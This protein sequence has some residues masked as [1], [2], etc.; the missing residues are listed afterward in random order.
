MV[1][2]L[3]STYEY[4]EEVCTA[5]AEDGN[6]KRKEI[7]APLAIVTSRSSIVYGPDVLQYKLDEHGLEVTALEMFRAEYALGLGI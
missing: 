4:I 1:A 7:H 3:F 5:Q 2:S 6:R